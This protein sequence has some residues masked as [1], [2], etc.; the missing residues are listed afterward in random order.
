VE[1]HHEPLLET[2]DRLGDVLYRRLGEGLVELHSGA[3]GD[4]LGP[5]GAAAHIHGAGLAS[6][7]G[8]LG[9]LR[10]A[11]DLR[12]GPEGLTD[13]RAPGVEVHDAPVPIREELSHPGNARRVRVLRAVPVGRAEVHVEAVEGVALPL[14]PAP[15]PAAPAAHLGL[16][17]ELVAH[18]HEADVPPPQKPADL[19][20][21]PARALRAEARR[22]DIAGR[23]HPDGDLIAREGRARPGRRDSGRGRGR[24]RRGG[25]R[26]W[27][28]RRR[29]R[30]C[31]GR[32]V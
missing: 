7:A 14:A 8:D 1:G 22:D 16:R 23:H 4:W 27:R 3:R 20:L 26:P 24:R 10:P 9:L 32:W 13:G 30:G 19:W 5:R 12:R 25:G 2:L 29:G 18:H 6:L 11:L 17:V 15:A 28:R 31:R 21:V